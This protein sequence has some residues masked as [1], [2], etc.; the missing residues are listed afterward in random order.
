M[1]TA[2]D[3]TIFMSI[4][5]GALYPDG[6][7]W[8]ESFVTANS[9]LGLYGQG[10]IGFTLVRN[11]AVYGGY[12]AAQFDNSAEDDLQSEVNLAYYHLGVD[13][14]HEFD[15]LPG[16]NFSLGGDIGMTKLSGNIYTHSYRNLELDN[17]SSNIAFRILVGARLFFMKRLAAF[18]KVGYMGVQDY[19]I[20]VPA[21]PEYQLILPLSG[22]T[23]LAGASFYISI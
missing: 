20:T 10:Q 17:L 2:L 1:D 12:M 6:D 22:W 9:L 4:A 18:L 14:L 16:I 15:F 23:L 7:A 13:Y 21:E 19:N 8:Q 5:G 3:K 11:I